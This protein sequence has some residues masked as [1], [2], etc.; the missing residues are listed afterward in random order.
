[1]TRTSGAV[2]TAYLGNVGEERSDGSLVR[3][4]YTLN[5]Q[6]VAVRT[7]PPTTSSTDTCTATTWAV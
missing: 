6:A 7:L 4:T 5:G 2:T 1:V 3:R